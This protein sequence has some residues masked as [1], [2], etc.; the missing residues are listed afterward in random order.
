MLTIKLGLNFQLLK[1]HFLCLKSCDVRSV[2]YGLPS[3]K[4]PRWQVPVAPSLKIFRGLP[5]LKTRSH[6]TNTLVSAIST[7]LKLLTKRHQTRLD[8]QC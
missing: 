6:T 8:R 7:P 5:P 4:R 2:L 1:Y 3:Q